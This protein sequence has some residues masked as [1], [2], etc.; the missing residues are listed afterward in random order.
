[1]PRKFTSLAIR[2]GHGVRLHRTRKKRYNSF[3]VK[4]LARSR[5]R[6]FP[7]SSTDL[8]ASFCARNRGSKKGD[9]V[10]HNLV[11][12]GGFETFRHQ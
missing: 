12:D 2:W 11:I 4:N 6:D 1:M 8:T 7:E 9:K 5:I 3:R 10:G